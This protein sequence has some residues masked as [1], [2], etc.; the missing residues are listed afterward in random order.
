M[1]QGIVSENNHKYTISA[2][3]HPQCA[4][5]KLAT[6]L[7]HLQPESSKFSAVEG[8]G[9]LKSYAQIYSRLRIGQAQSPLWMQSP[10]PLG[11]PQ[12]TLGAVATTKVRPWHL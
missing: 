10:Q 7:H 4:F 12:D 3:V 5:P 9:R 6:I 1:G 8:A 2:K 11:I